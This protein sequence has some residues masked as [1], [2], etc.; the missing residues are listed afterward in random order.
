MN[1][2]HLKLTKLQGDFVWHSHPDS[3]E[4]FI[5]LHGQ[6]R[7]EFREG[8]ITLN[9]GEMAVVPKGVEH[10]PIAETECHVLFVERAGTVN[11]GDAPASDATK[12]EGEWI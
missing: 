11:T 1:D 9:Q 7:V 5:V 4:V 10:K 12:G 8:A 6:L 3:D 2:C